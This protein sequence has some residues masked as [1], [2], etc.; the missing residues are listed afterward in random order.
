[1]KKTL[2]LVLLFCALTTSCRSNAAAPQPEQII[3]LERAALDRW[4]NGDPQGYIESMAPELTYFDP[5]QEKR[6]D[7]LATFKAFAEPLKGKVKVSRY[8]MINPKVQFHS[9]VA[10]LTFNLQ[11]Y[12]KQGDAPET[13]AASWNSTEVYQK[14]DD[15]WKIIH[16]HWSFIR[17][18]VAPK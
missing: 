15:G 1:M 8:N 18:A 13:L 11:S 6:V 10:L 16:S 5:F 2:S 7:G 14:V 17:P 12:A 4:G 3:A 9:D